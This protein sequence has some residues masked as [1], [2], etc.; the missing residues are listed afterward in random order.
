MV[1]VRWF[2]GQLGIV[3]KLPISARSKSFFGRAT[4]RR[5]LR[6]DSMA[7]IL[8]GAP[9]TG[10]DGWLSRSFK[11]EPIQNTD[12]FKILP[13]KITGQSTALLT[14]V[15]A[16]SPAFFHQAAS[17]FRERGRSKAR[18]ICDAHEWINEI[19]T[20]PTYYLA[21]PQPRE[22]AWHN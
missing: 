20:V 22:R 4:V 2:D 11:G 13:D 9:L 18:L 15:A 7:A 21:K 16:K 10:G 3:Y 19:P 14:L 1:G 8:P 17:F 6:P 12:A 5:N